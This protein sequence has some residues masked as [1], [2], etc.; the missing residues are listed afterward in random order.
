MIEAELAWIS[1][2]FSQLSL[3]A[4]VLLVAWVVTL[5]SVPI[6][7]WTWDERA[8]QQGITAG[9]LL[10]SATVLV[11]LH[12]ALGARR[13]L[14]TACL[15]II[16]GWAAEFLGSHTGIPFGRYEY[17][18]KLQPQ[19]GEVPVIIPIAWLMMLPPAWAV[20]SSVAP[21]S[22]L[23][24]V[25]T[26]ALAF[27]AWDLFL[28]PQMVSWGMWTWS[29]P[30]PATKPLARAHS[31]FGIPWSNYAGWW[32]VSALIS[33]VAAPAELP[34]EPLILIYGIT[35]FL[36]LFGQFFFWRLRGPALAG[37]LGMGLCLLAAALS[38]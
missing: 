30:A 37:G 24:F 23:R 9:V 17:T 10:Q 16:L 15:V 27:T 31:Y 22:R 25:V 28:D 4:Q 14:V 7:R 8:Q 32:L 6:V 20:A 5:I 3:P 38:L 34:R 36:E 26:S 19:V 35:W 18:A 11:I 29:T 33:W 12:T 1:T 21:G 2:T 13:T